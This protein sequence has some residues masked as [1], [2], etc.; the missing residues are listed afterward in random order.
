MYRY[1]HTI[2]KSLITL[3]LSVRLIAVL[4]I[5]IIGAVIVLCGVVSCSDEVNLNKNS[6]EYIYE[7]GLTS[8]QISRCDG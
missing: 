7:P 8:G 3:V 1:L 2:C 6:Q 4:P 5:I